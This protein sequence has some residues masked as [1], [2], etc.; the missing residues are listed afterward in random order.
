[1]SPNPFY[2]AGVCHNLIPLSAAG[3][4]P[5]LHFPFLPSLLTDV[6]A[7]LLQVPSTLHTHLA[8]QPAHY[9]HTEPYLPFALVAFSWVLSGCGVLILSRHQG[10]LVVF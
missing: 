7:N 1:M 8:L 5:A 9:H 10:H 2:S 6:C 3:S 4:I